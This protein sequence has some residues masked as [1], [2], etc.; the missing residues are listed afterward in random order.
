[1]SNFSNRTKKQHKNKDLK[2]LERKTTKNSVQ[3]RI[4]S[5]R[6]AERSQERQ[7]TAINPVM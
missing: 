5:Y 6:S 2:T 4:T 7:E 1:L 3:Y